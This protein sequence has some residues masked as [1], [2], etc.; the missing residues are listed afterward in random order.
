MKKGNIT[1]AEELIKKALKLNPGYPHTYYDLALLY[2][3]ASHPQ[4]SLEVLEKLLF[5]RLKAPEIESS[6][7]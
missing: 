2:K 6:I 3:A 5:L 7:P 4:E 1:K